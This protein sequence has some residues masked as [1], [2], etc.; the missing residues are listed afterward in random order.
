MNNITSHCNHSAPKLSNTKQRNDVT[1]NESTG[2]FFVR[3]VRNGVQGSGVRGGGM[4]D[5]F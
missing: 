3:A 5:D 4:A 2:K 1:V